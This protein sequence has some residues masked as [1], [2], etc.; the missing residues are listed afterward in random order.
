MSVRSYLI[1]LK[2]AIN[3]KTI[4]LPY[5]FVTGNQ[6]ADVDSVI[7]SITY[8][9]LTHNLKTPQQYII[10]LINV[11]KADLK[12]R[13]DIIRVLETYHNITEDL[14]YFVED[15]DNF[16]SESINS[17]VLQKTE[18]SLV[19][20]NG[21]QGVEINK[22]YDEGYLKV[23][24]IIDHHADE[25]KFLN[26]SP[27]I[28]RS[29]G[30]NSSLVFQ[31]FYNLKQN[32]E[33]FWVDN[34]DV[35]ELLIAPLLIDTSNMTQKVEEPDLEV[36]DIY[37]KI[38]SVTKSQII[39][40]QIPTQSNTN[41]VDLFYKEIKKAKKDLS[42]FAFID[43]LR[44]DYKQF[45]FLKGDNI[46]FSSIGKPL[47]WVVESYTKEEILKTLSDSLKLNR[48]DLLVITSSYTVKDTNEYRREFC[49]YYEG[50]NAVYEILDDLVETQLS[51]NNQVYGGDEIDPVLEYVNS[52]SID[53]VGHFK[54][55]NQ[56]NIH[57]SR[58]QVVPI[59]K[60]AL[61]K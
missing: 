37:K 60:E 36:F 48:I 32:N 56:V 17:K 35:I 43:I 16:I 14:L 55:Y 18:L 53:N 58:K 61:E 47:K 49:Y 7:S 59:V 27:R 2:N 57:A 4:K 44:K 46:G 9:Y 12:L 45:K 50:I 42:G 24:G 39:A 34:K 20:H 11:P 3:Q 41:Q 10:P 15:F 26:A 30:S 31:Y 5:T 54:I 25:G 22:S 19:D 21:L 51:L 38:L 29:C 40:S 1:N 33:Q 6:S 28:I 52:A 13:R 23:V 8:A